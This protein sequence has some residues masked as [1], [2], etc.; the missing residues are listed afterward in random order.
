MIFRKLDDGFSE[1]VPAW[2][3]EA[4][5]LLGGGPSLTM[6]Q[7]ELVKAAYESGRIRCGAVNDAYLWADFADVSYFADSHW[8]LDHARGIAKPALGL[9]AEQVRVRFA[10]FRGQKCSIQTSGA[11]ITDPAVHIVRN[12]HFPN[13][14]S[15]LSLDPRYIVTG[16]NSAHQLTNVLILAGIGTIILLGIDGRPATDGRTHWSGGHRRP[17]PDAAY[18]QYRRGWS[19]AERE[20]AAAG[21]RVINAS[22]GSGI[23]SFE[24][25]PLEDALIDYVY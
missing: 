7:V 22:P 25:M 19:A 2:K 6:A 24:K 13:M 9:T 21:V 20:I 12:K 18:E 16:W 10:S 14:G 8:W 5:A 15:G 1:V 17:T 3:G 4:C 11:N 23:D